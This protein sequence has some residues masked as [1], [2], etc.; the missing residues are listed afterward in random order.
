MLFV[1]RLLP[2][3]RVDLLLDTLK[4][5]GTSYRLGIVGSGPEEERL[6]AH[7]IQLG[8]EERVRFYG[9]LSE[10]SLFQLMSG[11]G[12]LVQ[13]SEQEGQSIVVLE[14][15]ACGLP[16][17]VATSPHSG[18]CENFEHGVHGLVVDPTP[19]AF[20]VAIRQALGSD[21]RSLLSRQARASAQRFDWAQVTSKVEEVYESV[22]QTSTA[23][24]Q[25]L[26]VL[27]L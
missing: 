20:S 10:D 16:P 15:M 4:I 9:T 1:G 2:H 22:I 11:S 24:C 18:A 14:A 13:P 7:S 6:K 8:V 5:L 12:V 25:V 21:Y 27:E 23:E 26:P 19:D 3:K 17:I